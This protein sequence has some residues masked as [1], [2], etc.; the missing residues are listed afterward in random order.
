MR[1]EQVSLAS[2]AHELPPDVVTSAALEDA[3]APVYRKLGL[4]AGRLELLSGVRERRFWAPGTP[5][6]VPSVR[7]ARE[8]IARAG[9]DPAQVGALVHTSVCRDCLEPATASIVAGQ[10]GL[11]PGAMVFD[12]SNACLGFMNGLVT[13][14]NMIELGQIEAGV[15]VAT[16]SGRPLVDAT[17]A[18]LNE[19]SKNGLGKKDLRPAFASLTIGSGSVAAVLTHRRAA[20][21]PGRRL[22]GGAV[23]QATEHHALCRSAPDQGFAAEAHPLMDTDAEAVLENGCQLAARAW[24]A[25]LGELGWRDA[26]GTKLFCHQVGA[27]YRRTLFQALGLDVEADHPTLAALGNVGSVSCPISLSM[28]IEEG[29]LRPG[30]RLAMLGIG[31][32]LNS[33]MLGLSWA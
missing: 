9:L 19:K 7:T 23:Q 15:V 18:H 8:A 22:L 10:L 32:G 26:A 28:A 17:V 25:L 30:D 33:V 5:P 16:E 31:S 11:A 29:R 6:S 21:V 27:S 13:V 3:L 2:L 20:K 24:R 12:V 1:Y 14:A 4:N